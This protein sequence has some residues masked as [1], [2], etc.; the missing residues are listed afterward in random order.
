MPTSDLGDSRHKNVKEKLANCPTWRHSLVYKFT[1]N[2][3]KHLISWNR[4]DSNIKSSGQQI[5]TKGGQYGTLSY[6]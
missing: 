6:T 1:L 2:Y 4:Q 3:I 5:F